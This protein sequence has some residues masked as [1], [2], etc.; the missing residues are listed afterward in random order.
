MRARSWRSAIDLEIACRCWCSS[1]WYQYFVVLTL[2]RRAIRQSWMKFLR[3]RWKARR[4][5]PAPADQSA[6]DYDNLRLGLNVAEMRRALERIRADEVFQTTE[7]LLGA[8]APTSA[9]EA[10]QYCITL[11]AA[12]IDLSQPFKWPLVYRV[13]KD[14]AMDWEAIGSSGDKSLAEVVFGY[15]NGYDG[16]EVCVCVCVVERLD[17]PWYR[18]ASCRVRRPHSEPLPSGCASNRNSRRC[19]IAST[20]PSRATPTS[21]PPLSSSRGAS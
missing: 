7:V 19:R 5:P 15:V 12:G 17:E 14:R 10:G 2:E 4:S 13:L 8:S 16:L 21:A 18:T 1:Y 9:D 11:E 20:R 3:R 6:T